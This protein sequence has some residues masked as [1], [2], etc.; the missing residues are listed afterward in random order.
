MILV[1]ESRETSGMFAAI[2]SLLRSIS[3]GSGGGGG[4]R[5]VA[6]LLGAGSD[7][8]LPQVRNMFGPLFDHFKCVKPLFRFRNYYTLS[9]YHLM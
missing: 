6:G 5:Q 9:I 2:P 1:Y 8:Y 3:S 7:P 4:N